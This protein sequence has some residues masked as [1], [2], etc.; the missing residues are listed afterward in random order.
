MLPSLDL[1]LDGQNDCD[2][3]AAAFGS[4]TVIDLLLGRVDIDVNSRNVHG[5]TAL[6][7]AA[8]AA[9]ISGMARDF[10]RVLSFIFA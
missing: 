8:Y 1:R 9:R 6:W 2:L 4:E 7:H 5:E 10:R 3:V